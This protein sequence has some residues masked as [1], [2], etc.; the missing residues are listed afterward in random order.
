METNAQRALVTVNDTD[1]IK[2]LQVK[3][4]EVFYHALEAY[5]GGEAQLHTYS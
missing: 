4:S 3:L 1:Y 2:T 5:G